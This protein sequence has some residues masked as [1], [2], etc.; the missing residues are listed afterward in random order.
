[1]GHFKC[2][3]YLIGGDVV[4]AL[5]LVFLRERL[6]IELGCLKEREGA[7]DVGACEGK[8]IFDGAI[9][10][11]L[12]CKMYYAIDM[13]I[14]HELIESIE[15]ADIHLHKLVIRLILNILEVCQ[16]TSVSQLIQVDDIILRILVHE[17]T[18]NVRSDKS[19]STSNYYITHKLKI[20]S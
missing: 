5:A 18:N 6:P 8:R 17:K 19:S 7:H 9:D 10:M 1:M 20:D 3:I 11:A 13:L 14:L 12:G 16:I 4:E 15:V 2:T